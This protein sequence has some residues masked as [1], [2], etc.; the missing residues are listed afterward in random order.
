MR[1]TLLVVNLQ[2]KVAPLHTGANHLL[3]LTG[4][5]DEGLGDSIESCEIKKNNKT[6]KK[7]TSFINTVD[8]SVTKNF[9]FKNK[10]NNN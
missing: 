5:I 1:E 6:N 3:S 4:R 9:H 8:L 2:A 7:H 10:T